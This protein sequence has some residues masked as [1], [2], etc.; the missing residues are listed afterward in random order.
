MRTSLP[1]R[2]ELPRNLRRLRCRASRLTGEGFRID[3]F[4]V[5]SDT[6]I[7]F[8]IDQ[9]GIIEHPSIDFMWVYDTD[10][11][12]FT[13]DHPLGEG[14]PGSFS[15]F[16]RGSSFGC[17]PASSAR[18]GGGGRC[19]QPAR[20]RQPGGFDQ[21]NFSVPGVSGQDRDL[22]RFRSGSWSL[23]F[24]GDAVGLT[25]SDEDVDGVAVAG[26]KI[27][28][29]TLGN[30]TVN[31]L[32]GA[33][34]DVSFTTPAARR[35]SPCTSTAASGPRRQRHHRHR[36][37]RSERERA[38]HHPG[39]TVSRCR[40]RSRATNRRS[41]SRTTSRR[42]WGALRPIPPR[43]AARGPRWRCRIPSVPRWRRSSGWGS[44]GRRSLLFRS[45][46]R[47]RAGRQRRL[48]YESS[49]RLPV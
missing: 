7:L 33:D 35:V 45:L 12:K 19:T 44:R 4:D 18:T 28:L 14:K 34:E 36:H 48:G 21:G 6:E 13:S 38:Q 15:L 24:N 29:S 11:I 9:T 40:R 31:G 8:S 30:F 27:Y 20:R 37:P 25:T 46:L 2:L 42:E 32:S 39:A 1:R 47:F 43:R 5:I 41:L 17:R 22:I 23:Y 3:A 10:V 49:A 16:F 26:G